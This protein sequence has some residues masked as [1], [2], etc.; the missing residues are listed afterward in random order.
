MLE[1]TNLLT[2]MWE[3]KF[4]PSFSVLSLLS[5]WGDMVDR[6]IPVADQ[7]VRPCCQCAHSAHTAFLFPS[8]PFPSSLLSSPPYPS[9]SL[10][11][12]PLLSSPPPS[13]PI[14]PTPSP[15]SFPSLLSFSYVPPPSH[16][17]HDHFL[18]LQTAGH[19][20]LHGGWGHLC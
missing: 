18:P 2:G 3:N 16:S 1:T 7:L 11:A 20:C 19:H 12:L 17:N 6:R 10:L 14:S 13:P 15:S 8:L 4:D 9:P 5:E